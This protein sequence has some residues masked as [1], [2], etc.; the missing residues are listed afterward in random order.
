MLKKP[1]RT[2]IVQPKP[3]SV[4][5]KTYDQCKKL[6]QLSFNDSMHSKQKRETIASNQ[7]IAD[8]SKSLPSKLIQSAKDMFK[9]SKPI[10]PSKIPKEYDND[11]EQ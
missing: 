5:N 10:L 3:Q 9:S 2:P 8:I 6:E 11:L 1:N 7:R 4:L